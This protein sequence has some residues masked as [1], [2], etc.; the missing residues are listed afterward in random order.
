MKNFELFMGCLGNGITVCN[1]AVMEN[2]DFKK[3]CHIS[4]WGK[5]KWYVNINYVPPKDLLKIEY[6]ADVLYHKTNENF[7][8]MSEIKQL[9]WLLDN[10]SIT[11]FIEY[12]K[13]KSET[14]YEKI[15][16][17]KSRIINY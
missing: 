17:L 14:L 11:D 15:Q 12:T 6:Q 7:E 9:E 4:E 8:K 2:G 16:F 10:A 13:L 1:E 5:I 3:I